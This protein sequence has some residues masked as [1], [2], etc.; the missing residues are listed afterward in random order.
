V[1]EHAWQV[2]DGTLGPNPGITYLKWDAN[3]FVTQPGSSHLGAGE[4]Q[5]LLID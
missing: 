1:K 5:H 2:I 3:R 4:Q